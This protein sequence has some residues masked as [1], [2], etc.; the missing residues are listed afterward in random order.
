MS[1]DLWDKQ[2]V[3]GVESDDHKPSWLT[4]DEKA[5]CYCDDRGWVLVHLN[6]DEEV[7]VAASNRLN[8]EGDKGHLFDAEGKSLDADA[9]VARAELAKQLLDQDSDGI[10]SYR[11]PDKDG[12]DVL[13]EDDAD[14]YDDGIQ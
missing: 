2:V 14:E 10:P 12:D 9:I 4:A 6:G 11:D 3:G 7:L 13:N 8:K 5:R 1:K